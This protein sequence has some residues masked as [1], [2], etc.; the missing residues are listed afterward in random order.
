MFLAAGRFHAS[1]ST[2]R[3]LG[4][5]HPGEER[6]NPGIGFGIR[7]ERQGNRISK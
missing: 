7:Q 1:L 6:G 4:D 3:S 5:A 2:I